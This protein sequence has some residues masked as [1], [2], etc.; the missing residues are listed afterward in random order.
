M[1]TL[2]IPIILSVITLQIFF[3]LNNSNNQPLSLVSV[4]KRFRDFLAIGV[5]KTAESG[6]SG[7]RLMPRPNVP[8]T[9]LGTLLETGEPVQ[10]SSVYLDLTIN[11][12]LSHER[13]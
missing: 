9:T 8:D 6:A 11:L 12:S 1:E 4:D 10:N 13:Q 3:F 5:V 7:G 2:Q